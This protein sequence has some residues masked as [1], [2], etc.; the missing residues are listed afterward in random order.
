MPPWPW[1]WRPELLTLS[2]VIRHLRLRHAASLLLQLAVLGG[3]V[4]VACWPLNRMDQLQDS[5]LGL[6]PGFSNGPWTLPGLLVAASPLLVMPLLLLLQRGWL[7]PGS[8][9]G[10]P[11]TMLSL[12]QPERAARLLGPWAN[13]TRLVLWTLASLALFPLGREGPV[14]QVGA[15][16]ARGLR[17]RFPRL[18]PAISSQ[19]LMAVGA[20]AGLAGGFNSPLMGL[21]FVMEELTGRFQVA[22]LWPGAVVGLAAA[23]VSNLGGIGLFPLGIA[24]E[25]VAEPLQ[26]LWAL[27]LGAGGGLLGGLLARLLVAFTAWLRPRLNRRPITWGIAL[28][29]ALAAMALLSG[30]WSGGDGEALMHHLLSDA[31]PQ[32]IPGSP[33]GM[34]GWIL[35]ITARLLGPVLAMG[36][37]VPGGL[38]DP[39]FSLGAVF[40]SGL[41]DLVGGSTALGLALG[42][43]GGLAGA[44]QLPL[45]TVLFAMRMAGD[46]QWLWGLLLSAILGAYM[47]RRLQPKPVYHAL[48]ELSEELSERSD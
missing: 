5:L 21:V 34:A 27:P 30:G 37:G 23:L 33:L 1:A 19:Q 46:A 31:P 48:T 44:T 11:Q 4:G 12:E 13:I 29:A 17:Q 16:A 22:V 39:A 36:A 3:L 26:L 6:L 25:R 43:A 15:A 32:P 28:G 18:L 20:G 45:T 42:M 14:V 2:A 7:R 47:G 10:I 8:G 35:V 38:I 24:A 9:S 40:G 41:M